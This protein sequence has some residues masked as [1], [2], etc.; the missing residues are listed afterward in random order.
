MRP[1]ATS[2]E[3]CATAHAL[4]RYSEAD[5]VPDQEE[6]TMPLAD[7]SIAE[8]LTDLTHNLRTLFRQE[9][10]LARAE[11]TQNVH[12]ARRGAILIAAGAAL[13]IAGGLTLVAALCLGLVALGVPPVAAAFGVAVV[14]LIGAFLMVRSG[15]ASLSPDRVAPRATVETLKDNAQLLRG[16][17]R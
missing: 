7:R 1:T 11:F 3:L 13:A 2:D 4:A 15:R 8:L 6:A 16:H 14:L 5:L 10:A 9:L 12:E 17:M